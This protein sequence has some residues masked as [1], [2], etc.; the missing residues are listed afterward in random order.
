MFEK[1][2]SAPEPEKLR[3]EEPEHRL[4]SLRAEAQL[5]PEPDAANGERRQPQRYKGPQE[6][7]QPDQA[8]QVPEVRRS[9]WFAS[10]ER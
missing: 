3:P 10:P 9:P 2:S 6:R 8:D 5:A 4:G 7:E 1:V